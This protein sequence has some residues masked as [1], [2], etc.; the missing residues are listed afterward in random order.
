MRTSDGDAKCRSNREMRCGKANQKPW[1]QPAK[2]MR[3]GRSSRKDMVTMAVKLTEEAETASDGDADGSN[4][5]ST[6]W[7]SP[8]IATGGRRGIK[9]VGE[10]S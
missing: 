3:K 10:E 7:S 2:A 5:F 6:R 1:Q 8:R 4:G 9:A